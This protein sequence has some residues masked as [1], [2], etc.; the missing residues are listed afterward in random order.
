MNHQRIETQIELALDDIIDEFD[1]DTNREEVIERLDEE[2]DAVWGELIKDGSIAQYTVSD[3]TETAEQCATIIG[4]AEE[5]AWV[6]TD[7]GLWQG[8]TY[9]VLAS[10][11]YFSLRNCFYQL[12]KD[13]GHNTD[14]EYP[15]V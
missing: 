8:L 4:F 1:A 10:I 11:A 13:R 6:E 7:G 12:L 5:R 15:F 9:G 2:T 3:L 14:N